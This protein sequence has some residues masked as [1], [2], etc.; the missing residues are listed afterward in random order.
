[1]VYF[2]VHHNFEIE[3][4]CL[5]NNVFCK[6]S[7]HWVLEM[8]YT[9][10]RAVCRFVCVYVSLLPPLITQCDRQVCSRAGAHQAQTGGALRGVHSLRQMPD[11]F[12]YMIDNQ[13]LYFWA[14][15]HTDSQSP[16]RELLS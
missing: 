14:R 10:H 12:V 13:A 5:L 8:Y 4:N 7:A 1:M 15:I 6:Q 9:V 3:W 11:C 2:N 16:L